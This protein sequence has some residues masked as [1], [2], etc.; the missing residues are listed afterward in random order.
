MNITALVKEFF[1]D[2]EFHRISEKVAV[3]RNDGTV[4]YSNSINSLEASNI[5][6]LASGIWQAAQSLSSLVNKELPEDAYRMSFDTSSDGIYLLPTT[7][8]AS[9]CYFCC[10]FREQL[11]PGKLKQ[12]MRNISFLLEAFIQEETMRHAQKD[13]PVRNGGYLFQNITDEEM[14]QLFGV[15]GI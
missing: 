1:V 5:G 7:L 2:N 3:V 11:N 6:A 14:D 15:A 13:E 12:S 8:G 4:L 10:I 9:Q